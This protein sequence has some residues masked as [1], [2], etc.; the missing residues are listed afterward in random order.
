ME[1]GEQGYRELVAQ[2]VKNARAK[3]GLSQEAFGSRLAEHL[4][5]P[6]M[7]RRQIGRYE[8][9]EDAIPAFYLLAI[10]Q[11]TGLSLDKLFE[12]VDT[13]GL[14][15]EVLELRREIEKMKRGNHRPR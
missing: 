2:M 7:D 11:L 6:A 12:D 9:G 8:R 14:R 5:R 13:E 10:K 15:L 4:G 1:P 3:M